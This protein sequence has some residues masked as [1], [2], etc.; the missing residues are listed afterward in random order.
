MLH[1]DIEGFEYPLF[2]R[3]FVTAPHALCNLNLTHVDWHEGMLKNS[4]DL[5][6]L[7]AGKTIR[8]VM[9]WLLTDDACGVHWPKRAK[10]PPDAGTIKYLNRI[11]NLTESQGKAL[12][13]T[14]GFGPSLRPQ[15]PMEYMPMDLR[16]QSIRL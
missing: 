11:R 8:T 10:G 2:R 3:L 6:L 4:S 12:H 7:A 1:S 14:N 15:N 9:E 16:S 13:M 5:P